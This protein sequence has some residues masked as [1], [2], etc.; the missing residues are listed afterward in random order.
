MSDDTLATDGGRPDR[1][2]VALLRGAD[3][4]PYEM[5]AYEPL[6]VEFD[7]LA[8]GRHR[9]RHETDMIGMPTQ[10]LASISQ[11]R[12]LSG[13]WRR[14]R[15]STVAK[16]NPDR[17]LGLPRL[18]RDFDILHAAETAIPLSEQAAELVTSRQPRLILTC[19]ETIPFR[20]DD[21]P[22]LSRRKSIVRNATSLFI[23]VTERARATL[24][25]EG[26]SADRVV[27]VP[28]AVDCERFH[29]DIPARG[30]RRQW[31]VPPSAPLVV[32]VG[33][34]IRE[35]GLVELLRA[36]GAS[37]SRHSHL[38]FVGS[39]DQSHRL[40]VAATALGVSERIRIVP[41]VSYADIPG[42][43]AAADVVVAPSLPTPYWEEQFG[44]VLVEA[45]A[46]GR[47][48]LSTSSGA[49]S[50]V[51]G[52]G[53]VLVPP[54]D[55]E[56]LSEALEQLLGDPQR[57]VA[58]GQRAQERASRLYAIPRVAPQL[59]DCYRRVLAG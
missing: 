11:H 41:S 9:G 23:A 17:L 14:A 32:Y 18:I 57:R 27:V 36:F 3:L 43:Y 15:A 37:S 5:Q 38:V 2:R 6:Q 39:G 44:M 24:L 22:L 1:P 19:W 13:M 34:L 45:M 55:P 26:V 28:A 51:V 59:A 54:Y 52:D 42:V 30:F 16:G 53:A 7:L 29:P 33:R 8:V 31:D 56:A 10:L 58:L 48:L 40:R 46:S 47:A 20:F 4:N 50:E 49:I 21:D 12:R 25:A 35:K